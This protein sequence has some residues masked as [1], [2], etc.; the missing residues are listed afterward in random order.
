MAAKITQEN[1]ILVP[2][3]YEVFLPENSNQHVPESLDSYYPTEVQREP[4][5]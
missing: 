3:V 4:C 1:Q 2:H 5:A